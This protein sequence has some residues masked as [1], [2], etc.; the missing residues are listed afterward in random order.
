MTSEMSEADMDEVTESDSVSDSFER[1]RATFFGRWSV[2]AEADNLISRRHLKIC[3]MN[4]VAIEQ[5]LKVG[6]IQNLSPIA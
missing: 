5:D 3:M 1:I 2:K 6:W 4:K